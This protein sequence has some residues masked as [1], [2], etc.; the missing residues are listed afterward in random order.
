VSNR[1]LV[2]W[3][4]GL[5]PPVQF[6]YFV[7]N[8]VANTG[9]VRDPYGGSFACT[10]FHGTIE[11]C[12]FGQMLGNALFAV[13][14]V[15]FISFGVFFIATACMIALVLAVLRKVL[16]KHAPRDWRNPWWKIW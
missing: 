10:N 15:N 2:L 13:L 9:G 1:A 4:L 16:N 6:L 3:S 8:L 11:A 7:A 12:T 14:L 5:T